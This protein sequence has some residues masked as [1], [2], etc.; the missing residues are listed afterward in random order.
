MFDYIIKPHQHMKNVKANELIGA[1]SN[2]MKLQFILLLAV[3]ANSCQRTSLRPGTM[4][5]AINNQ[6][7][8]SRAATAKTINVSN[9]SQLNAALSSAGS[10]DV[11]VLANG[12]YS[13]FTVTTSGITIQAASK[14]NATIS[15]GIIRFSKVSSVLIRGLKITTGGASET[16]DGETFPVAV[17]FEAA[18]SCRLAGCT[19]QLSSP[20][21]GTAWVML[22][23]NSN[24]N[25]VDHNAFGPNS[26]GGHTHYIFVR[27]NRTGITVPSDRTSWAEGNGP[28][29]PNMA[30]YTTIDSNYFHDMA[31]GDGEIMVLGGI[32]VAGDYQDT[33]THVEKNLF[34]NCD[35]DAE[36]ISI[37]SSSNTVRNN[38]IRT[39]VG[40]ISCRSGNG[41]TVTGNLLLQA[42]K[43]GTG[44]IKIYEKNHTVTGNY[45][46]NPQDY[47]FVL[48]AGDSYTSS[49]FSHAQVF[50]ATVTGNILIDMNTRGAI[51]GHG[52]NDDLPPVN[53]TFSNNAL[54]GTASPLLDLRI[55]GNTIFSNNT[56]SGSNPAM[57]STPLTTSNTGPG[58]YT[59]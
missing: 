39:S 47:G 58:S 57:P 48:G 29:N 36:I 37:K 10:G 19:L 20:A 51:I 41:N 24:N 21:S 4:P 49:N 33:H 40:M 15:S 22:S 54:R 35:G 17:W 44:G 43:T 59:Y 26:V 6:Q 13:G 9:S 50:N 55:P 32:G 1:V 46:D 30:R 42:G 56:T 3:F 28:T 45:V 16:V 8:V 11:I 7:S 25:R 53:C 52:S 34:V 5:P 12:S 2:A 38:T 27:G 14:G 23:G 18:T 31:S